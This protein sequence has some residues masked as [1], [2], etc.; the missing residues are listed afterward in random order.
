MR[1]L[2]LIIIFHLSVFAEQSLQSFKF[3]VFPHMPLKKL[4]AVFNVVTNDLE[5]QL[6][7]PVILMTKPYY[8]L[9]KEELNQGFYDFAFIQPLDYVQAHELQGYIPLARRSKDLKSIVV[10]LKDS[11][12][13][14]IEDIKEKVIASAP[15]QAAVTQ[16]ILVSLEKKGY[17]VLDDF[18]L[19]YSKNHFICLQKVLDKKAAGCVTAKRAVEFFN[20]EKEIDGF[21]VIYETKALPHALFVVHPRVPMKERNL[22]Q[23]RILHWGTEEKG[24]KM[25][26]KGKLLNFIKAKDTDY[27]RVREFLQK[28]G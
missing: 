13:Q 19:S 28:K 26:K 21:R 20:Q 17:Q 22:I 14:S 18:T 9:Y 12:Y 23:E 15:A 25:L 3:G 24:R 7:Q 11:K 1:I 4:H 6:G 27:N 2:V 8:K 5:T 16:M 10:V